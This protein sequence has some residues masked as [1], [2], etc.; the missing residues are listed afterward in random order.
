MGNIPFGISDFGD[1]LLL[2][3][4]NADNSVHWYK[5]ALDPL[6]LTLQPLFGG[7]DHYLSTLAEGEFLNLHETKHRA[8]SNFPSINLI[9]FTLIVKDHAVYMSSSH[10]LSLLQLCQEAA[11]G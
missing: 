7:I 3:F 1:T 4:I 8:I 9:D 2:H 6:K 11:Q 5:D 10:A